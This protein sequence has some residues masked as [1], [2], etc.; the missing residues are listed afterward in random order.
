MTRPPVDSLEN[1]Y[2][3]SEFLKRLSH[4]DPE[5]DAEIIRSMSE[6]TKIPVARV[7]AKMRTHMHYTNASTAEH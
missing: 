5:Y 1:S 4:I 6:A 2:F 7:L 3:W